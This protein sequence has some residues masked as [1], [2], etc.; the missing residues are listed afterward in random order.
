MEGGGID[1]VG[2]DTRGF[3]ESSLFLFFFYR[4][5]LL[6][7][8]NTSRHTCILTGILFFRKKQD[9]M[10]DFF[11]RILFWA[12]ISAMWGYIGRYSVCK[13]PTGMSIY[14]LFC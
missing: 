14:Q 8:P 2:G 13:I 6:S 3:R 1:D 7:V 11:Y 9:R 4:S 5:V 10:E 12:S